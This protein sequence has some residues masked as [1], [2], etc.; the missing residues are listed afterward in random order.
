MSHRHVL[1]S[2]W[3][4][5][6]SIAYTDICRDG[7]DIFHSV[8]INAMSPAWM[9]CLMLKSKEASPKQIVAG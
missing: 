7:E 2:G 6:T 8:R 9:T 4:R 5:A 1:P 3:L